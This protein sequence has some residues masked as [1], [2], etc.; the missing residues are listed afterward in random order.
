MLGRIDTHDPALKPW[1]SARDFVMGFAHFRRRY[2]LRSVPEVLPADEEI[3]AHL[4]YI[5]ASLRNRL[6]AFFD[7]LDELQ[8]LMDAANRPVDEGGSS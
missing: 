2:P 5:E 4:V 6:G 7:S 8:D 3:V 1:K